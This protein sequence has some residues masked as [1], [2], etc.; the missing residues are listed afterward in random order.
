MIADIGRN[1]CL[2]TAPNGDC[3]AF[4]NSVLTLTGDVS[5]FAAGYGPAR[6]RLELSAVEKRSAF[7]ALH[8]S[9][10]YANGAL[11]STPRPV[12]FDDGNHS[13]ASTIAVSPLY[14]TITPCVGKLPGRAGFNIMFWTNLSERRNTLQKDAV[15]AYIYDSSKILRFENDKLEDV[16]LDSY[17]VKLLCSALIAW[18]RLR[19]SGGSVNDA[20]YVVTPVVRAVYVLMVQE[21]N[22][23]I[24]FSGGGSGGSGG[25]RRHNHADNNNA[26]FA[27]AVFAPGTSLQPICWK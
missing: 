22:I 4:F 21:G 27:Y 16:D 5:Y 18:E 24:D 13:D 2:L 1:P 23:A 25:L 19:A 10:F 15:G 26:G 8:Y 7:R 14:E 9:R 17:S 12:P 6:Y 11:D 20:G 3:F